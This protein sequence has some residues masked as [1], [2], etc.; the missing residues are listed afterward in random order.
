MPVLLLAIFFGGGVAFGAERSLPGDILYP[1]KV[2]I[3]EKIVGLLSFSQ[4]AKVSWNSRLAVRRLVE[5]DAVG[6][7]DDARITASVAADFEK[8]AQ[9]LA[10]SLDELRESGKMDEAQSIEESFRVSAQSHQDVVVMISGDSDYEST[11]VL[12]RLGVNTQTSVSAVMPDPL[13]VDDKGDVIAYEKQKSVTL[14]ED[15][16]MNASSAMT[17]MLPVIQNVRGELV[18]EGI[19]YSVSNFDDGYDRAQ[20]NFTVIITA[21]NTTDVKKTFNF[22]NG[23]QTYSVVDTTDSRDNQLCTQ[24]L[25]DIEL[26]PGEEYSWEVVVPTGLV[27]SYGTHRITVGVE[28]Y[29]EYT[30]DVVFE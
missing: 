18:K 27:Y 6:Q 9:K 15:S 28:G 22:S 4:E 13:P 25:V 12:A 8:Q 10:V 14:N 5:L 16:E 17:F 24:A 2:G 7:K 19:Q 23:C 26:H 29:Y 21:R 1:F 20:D 3:N 11:G 30:Q